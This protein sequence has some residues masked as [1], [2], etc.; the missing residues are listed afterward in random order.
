M[1]FSTEN[2]SQYEAI[3]N[4]WDAFAREYGIS[5]IHGLGF[6]WSEKTIDYCFGFKEELSDDEY[7]KRLTVVNTF[8]DKPFRFNKIEIP[9]S[10]W[11]VFEGKT[12]SL[13]V[14]YDKVYSQ[15]RP[16]Y[17]IET[18]DDSGSCKI[19][20]H[21]IVDEN[22]VLQPLYKMTKLAISMA[23]LGTILAS[24]MTV[25]MI[26]QIIMLA[27]GVIDCSFVTLGLP[28]I[29]VVLAYCLQCGLLV[30]RQQSKQNLALAVIKLRLPEESRKTI[31]E[32]YRITS[33]VE[34]II[35]AEHR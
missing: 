13:S 12:D 29:A 6:S 2:D 32:K 4:V 25:G 27:L 18:F 8:S 22:S 30:Q 1:T 24:V 11:N 28:I 26:F 10:S 17:E 3:G 9:D 34:S 7:L 5:N 31:A 35:D 19:S 20:V 33:F 16:D 15:G 23:T 14:L 21:Y